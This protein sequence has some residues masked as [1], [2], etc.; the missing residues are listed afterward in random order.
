MRHCCASA[1]VPHECA[2]ENGLNFWREQHGGVCTLC[3]TRGAPLI[4]AAVS[5]A[6]AHAIRVQRMNT[7]TKQLLPMRALMARSSRT[8]F[9][10]LSLSLRCAIRL[11]FRLSAHATPTYT[12]HQA[13]V[14]R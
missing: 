2:C 9:I 4:Q 1:S 14:L 6:P 5:V 8:I 10:G 12:P 13:N 3:D 7:H 11:T